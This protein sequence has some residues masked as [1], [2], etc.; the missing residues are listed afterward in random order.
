M[1]DVHRLQGS[2][3]EFKYLIDEAM[4]VSLRSFTEGYLVHDE[5]ADPEANWEYEVC[6]LYLDSP[7]LTLCRSTMQGHKNRFK[8]RI[9]FY[10]HSPDSPAYFEIKRRVNDVIL[11]QRAAARREA[12]GRLLAGGWPARADLYNGNTAQFGALE[13][14]C[15]LRDAIRAEGQA[16]V[17]YRREAYVTPYNNTVRLTFDRDLTG[18][19]CGRNWAMFSSQEPVRPRLGGV[20]LEVKFTDRFPNWLRQMVELFDLERRSMAKYVKCIQDLRQRPMRYTMDR[21]RLG[22]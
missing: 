6:S 17:S 19:P 10:E 2:R 22:A 14:F 13:R 15:A 11:K 8:L 16:F 3:F 18:F 4:V 1:P 20:I 7:S 21:R 9:R 5:H 12:V